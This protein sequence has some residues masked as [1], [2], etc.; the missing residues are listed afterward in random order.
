MH[1][2]HVHAIDDPTSSA[3]QRRFPHC[4][5]NNSPTFP[6]DGTAQPRRARDR[7]RSGRIDQRYVS[8]VAAATSVSL[9]P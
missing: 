3:T 5:A 4:N 2:F 8:S 7:G 6:I 1:V 9:Q